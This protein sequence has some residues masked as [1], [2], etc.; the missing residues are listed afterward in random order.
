MMLRNDFP[1]WA[2]E[3][4]ETCNCSK[5][6]RMSNYDLCTNSVKGEVI[7]RLRRADFLDKK[8]RHACELSKHSPGVPPHWEMWGNS[9]TETK[10]DVTRTHSVQFCVITVSPLVQVR[11]RLTYMKG[12]EVRGFVCACSVCKVV[13][14]WGEAVWAG[15]VCVWGGG[16]SLP[17]TGSSWVSQQKWAEERGRFEPCEKDTQLPIV[18]SVTI[19]TFNVC[20]RYCHGYLQSDMQLLYLYL[21]LDASHDNARLQIP[22]S[23]LVML[24]NAEIEANRSTS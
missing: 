7:Q 2:G 6:D 15:R 4:L 13:V 1:L 16:I 3:K 22:L 14:C 9:N 5:N 21:A 23:L 8:A 12:C 10:Y 11:W 19:H 17:D 18:Q 24:V 20:R